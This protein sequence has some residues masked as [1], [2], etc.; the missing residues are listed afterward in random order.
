MARTVDDP[1]KAGRLAMNMTPMIDVTFQLIIVF[2]CSM[3][4]RCL[5]E[6]ME[7]TL[8]KGCGIAVSPCVPKVDAVARVRLDRPSAAAPTGVALTGNRLGSAAEGDALWARLESA[9]ALLRTRD[10]ELVGE[11]D[12]G[13]EVAHGEVMRALDAF[14][15]A[16]VERVRFCGTRQPRR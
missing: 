11:I 4:F 14:R 2:L 8:P 12:A 7:A 15:G 10:P 13:P 3:K 9:I 5:D 1:A 6:K 16:E